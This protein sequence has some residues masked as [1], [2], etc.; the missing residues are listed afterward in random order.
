MRILLQLT[1]AALLAI[2]AST[3]NADAPCPETLNFSVKELGTD[4]VVNLCE[5]YR[6][7]V[8][9]VVNTASKCGFTPQYEGLEALYSR[10]RERGL[11]VLGFPSNDFG[12]QE[13]GN[14]AQIKDFCKMTYGVKFP[15]FQKMTVRAD[16][17]APLYQT[18]GRLAQQFPEWNFH[19]YLIDRNGKLVASFPSN[20]DP[21]DPGF[22]AAIE[23]LL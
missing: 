5:K 3:A 23:Q 1:S 21:K 11:A 19:K 10:Y 4:N 9:L 16:N 14:E 18:L 17:A 12:S 22:V 2:A 8:V 20:L 13:P 7:Q 15:M 6:G